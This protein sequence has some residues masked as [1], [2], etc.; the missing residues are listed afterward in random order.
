MCVVCLVRVECRVCAAW[1][2]ACAA[3]YDVLLSLFCSTFLR[4]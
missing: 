2:V 3:V 4:S 1:R